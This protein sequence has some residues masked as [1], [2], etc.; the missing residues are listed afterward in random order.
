MCFRHRQS[1]QNFHLYQN[2]PYYKDYYTNFSDSLITEIS[3]LDLTESHIYI[4]TNNGIYKG[5]L[6]LN[7]KY[8]SS[9]VQIYDQFSNQFEVG[10]KD[11]IVNQYEVKF[12]DEG[13]WEEYNIDF[14]GKV[15]DSVYKNDTLYVLTEFCYYEIINGD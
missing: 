5:D 13:D 7:L 1:L 12:Y 11:Y 8:S 6:N 2:L 9:W 4:T 15:L 10:D 14:D 3:D